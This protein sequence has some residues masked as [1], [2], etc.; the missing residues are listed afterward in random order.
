M[1]K[2]VVYAPPLNDVPNVSLSQYLLDKLRA[3]ASQILQIDTQTGQV[4]T[5]RDIL[6]KSIILS[7]TLKDYGV[8][9][10]DRISVTSENHPNYVVA[11][12]GALFT[13]ATFAP[14][15]P[16]YTEREFRRML[17]LYQP[18]I[19]FVSQK[20]EALLS[21]IAATLNWNL[22]IIQLED[23]PLNKNI[24]T[25]RQILEKQKDAVNFEHFVPQFIDDNARRVAAIFCSSGTTGFP[26]GVMLSH[27]NLV[28]FIYSFRTPSLLELRNGDRTLLFLPL[29]HGYAV[30]MIITSIDA[31]AAICLMRK[32]NMD[33]FLATIEK[34]K[35]TM[36]PIVPPILVAM[37][38]HPR[39]K[40]Y[41]FGSVREILCGAAPLPKDVSDD[42]KRLTG[43]KYVRNGY[44]MTELSIITN[45]SERSCIDDTVGPIMPGF[46]GKIV[47]T[48]TGAALPPRK[49]GEVC[50]KG[51]QVMVGYFKNPK[52]TADTIDKDKWLHSG[53]LGYFD[54]NGL[55]YITG[56]IKELIKYKGHQ[57]SPSEIEAVLLTHPGVK[58]V[59]VIGKPDLA[60]GELP[61]A[62]IVRQPGKNLT[63]NDMIEFAK[64]SMSPQ[65]WLRA[66]VKFK[67]AEEMDVRTHLTQ[68]YDAIDKLQAMNVEINGDLLTVMILNSLPASF[69]TFRI[70][71]L[72]RDD[73][74]DP[75][76]LRIKII[77][78]DDTRKQKEKDDDNGAMFAR[79]GPPGG[80]SRKPH[81]SAD[82]QNSTNCFAKRKT[83]SQKA[84]VVEQTLIVECLQ[85]ST[86]SASPSKWCLDSGCTSHLCNDKNLFIESEE[87][88][89]GL[90]LAS[91]AVTQVTGKGSVR[92][93][94]SNG[95]VEQSF[96][97]KDTLLVPSLRVNLLSVSKIVDKE[98]QQACVADKVTKS[99][100]EIWH[101]RLGHLN[102][103]DMNLMKNKQIASG[104]NFTGV[105]NMRACES[106]VLSRFVEFKNFAE[107]QTGHK[108]KALQSD[109]GK[110]YCNEAMDNVLK[111]S[112][113]RRRLTTVHTPQQNGVNGV[114][115]ER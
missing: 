89:G 111:S 90:K 74:P 91:D 58:D 107:T 109:N 9:L 75:D 59:A 45:L 70:A 32:F 10:E 44:G 108:I 85:S 18:K 86:N 84:N 46:K 105:A 39:L 15:N 26:K 3:N 40:N 25:V 102:A 31:G 1:E 100:A 30:G 52:A 17:E 2:N 57:V 63:A 73:L 92:L 5:Y 112:G 53:D 56:R 42:V 104:L 62:V 88:N 67:M 60:A 106:D 95:E 51:D 64:K 98:S 103:N 101:E 50:L 36:L 99:S 65:Q 21:K 114:K 78:I 97:L 22:K 48:I 76:S 94:A 33:D 68:F 6:E 13:G 96:K 43:I 113:I 23:Q 38:K 72:S 35:V 61:M 110:E 41:N 24:I 81:A 27:K 29:F 16:D 87:T 49:I 4:Y 28:T 20:T 12:C 115:T 8:K 79:H 14:L 66:G 54:E 71:M 11:L 69:E 37:A 19:I 82:T 47:D 93:S 34:Y 83:A 80:Q 77:E 55:L 7:N